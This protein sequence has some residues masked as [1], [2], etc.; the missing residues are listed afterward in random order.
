M[1]LRV[2]AS[3]VLYSCTLVVRADPSQ[4]NFTGLAYRGG[5]AP[6]LG[7]PNPAYYNYV[8]SIIIDGGYRTFWCSNCPDCPSPGDH[9]WHSVGDGLAGPFGPKSVVM[10]PT[11]IPTDFDGEHT[12]D[13]S[14]I[15]VDGAYYL[16][17]GGCCGTDAAHQTAVGVA[18]STD[19]GVTFARM[20][21]GKAIVESAKA[22]TSS[23]DYGAGQPSVVYVT[24]YYY[25]IY[26]D[27]AS[28]EG[29]GNR[30]FAIRAR[31]PTFQANGREEWVNGSFL[32][33]DPA[34]STS[35]SIQGGA[36]S[37]CGS[38]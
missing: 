36:S 6:V 19:G 13:P 5:D 11:G 38:T 12:C 28:R 29:P 23:N 35:S 4:G 14:I 22:S 37:A 17:Y 25:M 3:A 8:P 27:V 10:S 20:N 31:E 9:V 26:T 34:T 30:L 21:E 33:Y 16:Y 15:A 7:N 2:F 1:S 32:P 24:P 18:M